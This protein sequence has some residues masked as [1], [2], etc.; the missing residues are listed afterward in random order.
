LNNKVKVKVTWVFVLFV[1][2]VLLQL[3]GLYLRDVIATLLLPVSSHS[4]G[5]NQFRCFCYHG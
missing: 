2:K 1:C 4:L 5:F 3:V